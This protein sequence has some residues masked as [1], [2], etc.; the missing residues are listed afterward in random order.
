[1]ISIGAE[2]LGQR[3][4]AHTVSSVVMN[5]PTGRPRPVSGWRI[6]KVKVDTLFDPTAGKFDVVLCVE[7]MQTKSR[8]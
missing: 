2:K 6:N 7:S 8:P 3:I 4:R 1:M 5:Q